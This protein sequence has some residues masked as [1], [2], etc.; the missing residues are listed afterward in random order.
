MLNRCNASKSPSPGR[1]ALITKSRRSRRITKG[2]RVPSCA[3]RLRDGRVLT[4]CNPFVPQTLSSRKGWF[5]GLFGRL[6]EC[7][8]L[9]AQ[10][11]LNAIDRPARVEDTKVELVGHGAVLAQQLVLVGAEAVVDVVAVLQVHSRFPEVHPACLEHATDERLDVDLEI[12]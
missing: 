7:L 1:V 3:S 11:V 10:L 2:F 9:T 4:T 6:E 12:E 8:D 5:G